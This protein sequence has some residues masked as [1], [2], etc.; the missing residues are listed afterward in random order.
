MEY[1]RLNIEQACA[2]ASCKKSCFY[3]RVNAGLYPKPRKNGK[4]NYWLGH[5]L[6]EAL[7]QQDTAAAAGSLKSA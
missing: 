3:D 2:L 6:V 7:Q 4:A 5:E 1:R